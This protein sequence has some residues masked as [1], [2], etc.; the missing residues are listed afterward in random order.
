M[1]A[2]RFAREV[3]LAARLQQANIVP[4][5][6]AGETRTGFPP[7]D[8]VRRDESLR[9]RMAAGP[10]PISVA[11][12]IHILRDVVRALAYAHGEGI[13]HRGIKP[14]NVLL[15]GGAAVGPG[16]RLRRTR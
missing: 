14:E 12:S 16:A 2:E 1:S 8:A 10:P 7:Y 3:G 15:S 6:A 11:D 9:A 5:L 13:V 4:V